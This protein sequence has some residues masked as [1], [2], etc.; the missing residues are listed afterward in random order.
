MNNKERKFLL[1]V[2]G[3]PHSLNAVSYAAQY[4][5]PAGIKVN[6]MHVIPT[7]PEILWDLE[8]DTHFKEKMKEKYVQW[9]R[10]ARKLAQQFLNEAMDLLAESGISENDVGVPLQERKVGIA[11]DIIE[12]SVRGY[13]AVV[14]GRAGLSRRDGPFLGSVSHKIVEKIQE[15]PVWVIGGDARAKRTLLA[16]DASGNSRKAVDYVGKVAAKTEVEVTLFHVVRQF[17]FLDNPNLC[18]N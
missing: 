12:E 18:F 11:R 3:S 17:K 6:L 5:S 9:T 2:D 4:C 10:N 16:V 8:K 1:A 13:E 15:I 14:V 7:A